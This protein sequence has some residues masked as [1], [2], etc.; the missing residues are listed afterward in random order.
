MSAL[1]K[2]V[3]NDLVTAAI[4]DAL[5]VRER[6][7][8][9]T[10]FIDICCPMCMSRGESQDRKFRCGIKPDDGIGV[11]CF[12]CGFR[13]RWRI[14]THLSYTMKAFLAGLGV[15]EREVQKLAYWANTL[16]GMM[17]DRPDI[18]AK[19][20]VSS[21]PEFKTGAL[22]PDAYPLQDWAE[23]E[24]NDPNYLDTVG[25][26]L[27]R[28]DVVAT[29]TTYYWTPDR[30]LNRRLIIPCYHRNNLVGWTARTITKGVEPRYHKEVPSNFLFNAD[31]LNQS[32]RKYV[33]IVEGVLDALVIDG[34]AALGAS[35]NDTQIGWIARSGKLPV[36][37]ADR[38]KRG[39]D[40]VEIGIRHQWPVAT[41]HYP[42]NQWW[43]EDIKD[44]ADAVKRFGK[45][46][47]IQSIVSNLTYNRTQIEQRIRYIME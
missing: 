25:Y 7:T 38:D 6:R 18:Q 43:A 27:S 19:L 2:L 13:C 34:V 21:V 37:V 41:M 33:F 32:R 8:A 23:M 4:F 35:L 20:Q 14:G 46:Y 10:G 24:C 47:T 30:A 22:P 3:E 26:L 5:T 39:K 15:P 36:V 1:D 29:A 42:G 40:L 11:N 28:G 45:L 12:N 31:V 44:C 17:V 9:R 16:K